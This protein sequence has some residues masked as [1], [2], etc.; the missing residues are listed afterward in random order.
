M[1]SNDMHAAFFTREIGALAD[2]LLANFQN[3]AAINIMHL[4]VLCPEFC[5][6]LSGAHYCE[7]NIAMQCKDNIQEHTMHAR[8]FKFM[9]VYREEKFLLDN[10]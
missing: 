6:Q 4:T 2:H 8:T 1:H 7:C 9:T 10:T 5:R 3:I